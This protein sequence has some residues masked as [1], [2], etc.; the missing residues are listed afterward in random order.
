M[1][2]EAADLL[3][4]CRHADTRQQQVRRANGFGLSR[5]LREFDK[6]VPRDSLL[7]GVPHLESAAAF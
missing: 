1:V 2:I 5:L 4:H 3:F 6:M 7:I